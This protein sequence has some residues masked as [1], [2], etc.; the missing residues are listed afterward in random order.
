VISEE[1]TPLF[2][3]SGRA[4]GSYGVGDMVDGSY[5]RNVRVVLYPSTLL[6][7]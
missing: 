3:E 2:R 1:T 5:A 6:L 4:G 7:G